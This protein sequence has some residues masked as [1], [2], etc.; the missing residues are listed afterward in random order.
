MNED[1]NFIE[2]IMNASLP[3]K[4]VMFLLVLASIS[5]WWIIFAKWM[6]L[7]SAEK[8]S[9]KF[10]DTFWS[11][12]DLNKLFDSLLK[13]KK[14]STGMEQIFEAG[15][16][17]F[18]RSRKASQ[19]DVKATESADRGMRIALNKEIEGLERHLPFLATIGS[20]SPYVGLLGTV[21]GIMISFQALSNVTQATIA[22]VAPGISEALIAT[23]MGLFAAIP[24]VIFYNNFN[25]KVERLYSSYDIFK[26]EFST[27]LHRQVGG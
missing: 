10:E 5:S 4:G 26:E 15:F 24:A 17:E 9:K 18:L 19:S 27:I 25:S 1:F 21:I 12:V 3:V 16:R 13:D 2:L 7:K 11:G 22:L 20:I 23:A 8:K 6:S 14:K